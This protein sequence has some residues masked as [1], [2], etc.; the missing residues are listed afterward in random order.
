M[1]AG[2]KGAP[3]LA[4]YRGAAPVDREVLLDVM[5][6]LGGPDGLL[7]QHADTIAE[8]D[9]NPL[10]VSTSGAVAVDARARMEQAPARGLTRCAGHQRAARAERSCGGGRICQQ[11]LPTETYILGS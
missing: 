2:L 11:S 3:L 10:I 6:A 7:M 4:G 9:V 8:F 1:L 5:M